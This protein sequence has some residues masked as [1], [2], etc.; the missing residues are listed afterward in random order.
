VDLI[1]KENLQ[2]ETATGYVEILDRQS[3]RLKKLIEDLVEASKVSTGNVSVDLQKTSVGVM[4]T[5]AA[6]EYEDRINSRNLELVL[7]QPEDEIFIM[8]DGRQLWRV[9]DNL[10]SNICKYAMGGTRVYLNL[11]RAN[12]KAMITFRNI[13][14]YALN[15]SSEELLERFTRGDRSR[16]TEGSGL[17]LSIA[18]SLTELQNG[19]MEVYT[20]GDLFKVV[21]SFKQI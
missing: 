1:K 19:E 2:N 16:H 14:A 3:K 4:L 7:N 6:G 8:A 5:Q 9:F 18:K 15:L 21:L 13:S 17:G 12:G 11:D 20:D 10:L